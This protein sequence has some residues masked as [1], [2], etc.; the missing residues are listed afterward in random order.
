MSQQSINP[1]LPYYTE[2]GEIMAKENP[3]FIMFYNRLS[4]KVDKNGC[5]HRY[6]NTIA[7]LSA[8]PEVQILRSLEYF[9]RNGG[10]CDCEVLLN[11]IPDKYKD[12]PPSR[13]DESE[14]NDPDLRPLG[15]DFR[16]GE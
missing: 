10:Y 13:E 14:F 12:E 15:N 4:A 9:Q 3:K 11:V 6:E 8:F 5:H 1:S 16:H 7:V 2:D